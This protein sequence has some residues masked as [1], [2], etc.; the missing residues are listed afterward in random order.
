MV[1]G[2]TGRSEPEAFRGRR[3]LAQPGHPRPNGRIGGEEIP[4]VIDNI[5]FHL[6]GGG[7]RSPEKI[8]RKHVAHAYHPQTPGL[9]SLSCTV[10][11]GNCS[12]AV[13]RTCPHGE[14]AS[15]APYIVP[16]DGVND[17]RMAFDATAVG[18]YGGWQIAM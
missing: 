5:P 13:W 16:W 12:A 3:Q 15:L 11:L 17:K 9:D 8:R 4:V 2:R 10:R 7:R 1:H 6:I 14:S 18:S